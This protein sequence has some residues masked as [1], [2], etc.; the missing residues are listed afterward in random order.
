MATRSCI[1]ERWRQV[2]RR[3]GFQEYDG[4]PLEELELYTKKS[5]AEIAEQLYCFQDKGDREISLRAEMTPTLGRLI[6]ESARHYRKPIKWFSIPQLFR[7]EKAQVK[8]G[9]LRE[10]FQLNVD[11]I[12]EPTLAGDAEMISALIDCLRVFGLTSDDFKVRLSSRDAWSAFFRKNGGTENNEYAFF[13]AIDKLERIPREET[14]KR[15]EEVGMTIEAVEAFISAS[16]PTEDLH[17]IIGDLTSRGL[18]DFIQVDYHIVRGLAYYTGVVYEVF[19]TE[20]SFRAIAGGGRYDTLI[21]RLSNE[22]VD[23]PAL[24]FGMGDVVLAELL[25]KK[26]RLPSDEPCLDLFLIIEDETLRNPTL[27]LAQEA[28]DANFSVEYSFGAVRG[29][30]QFKKA[31]EL[32]AKLTAKI[33]PENPETII[34]RRLASREES[35]ST[36]ENW[37]AELANRFPED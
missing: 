24:G 5:G 21:H 32:G 15:L 1:F 26:G 31:L 33:D 7:Y 6:A 2:V 9:R 23:L 11:I 4:P 22:K 12:G 3:Y 25:A 8:K 16:E 27:K 37:I 28:R 14:A 17:T 20:G 13:Q 36:K 19:D 29:D 10:H 30:K 34:I 35:T 18:G